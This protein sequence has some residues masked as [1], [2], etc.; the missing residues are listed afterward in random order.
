MLQNKKEWY[1][2]NRNDKLLDFYK[3]IHR[4]KEILKETKTKL[5]FFKMNDLIFLTTQGQA[6]V[7]LHYY[8]YRLMVKN[9]AT[10][11]QKK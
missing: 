7:V 6:P 1:D 9:L 3:R 8:M 10:E 4:M 2:W 11:D 5:D